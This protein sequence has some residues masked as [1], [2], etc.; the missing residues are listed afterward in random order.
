MDDNK[1]KTLDNNVV[2]LTE[3]IKS[4]PSY[5]DLITNIQVSFVVL[6]NGAF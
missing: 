6:T 1:E 3:D 5:K 4:M 2:K